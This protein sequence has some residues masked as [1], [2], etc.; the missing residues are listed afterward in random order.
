MAEELKPWEKAAQ[1]EAK[2][3][4]KAAAMQGAP[5]TPLS[6]PAAPPSQPNM[7]PIMQVPTLREAAGGLGAIGLGLAGPGGWAA[8]LATAT[9]GGA[10]GEA[11]G[12]IYDLSNNLKVENDKLAGVSS[13]FKEVPAPSSLK[14]SLYG[15]GKEGLAQGAFEGVAGGVARLAGGAIR[16]APRAVVATAE[17]TSAGKA[18]LARLRSVE[19]A[20]KI[21]AAEAEYASLQQTA[22]KNLE[23]LASLAGKELSAER[24]AQAQFLLRQ[25]Y[26]DNV[27]QHA[28]FAQAAGKGESVDLKDI[29]TRFSKDVEEILPSKGAPVVKANLSE[30]FVGYL[31]EARKAIK[32]TQSV[33]KF[34]DDPLHPIQPGT[35]AQPAE[36]TQAEIKAAAKEWDMHPVAAE[37][38]LKRM[39]DAG[40]PTGLPKVLTPEEAKAAAVE[41][42][43]NRANEE[44]ALRAAD[45][46]MTLEAYNKLRG[47]KEMTAERY[48][49]LFPNM[50]PAKGAAVPVASVPVASSEPTKFGKILKL[51]KEETRAKAEKVPLD[52][53][54]YG[55]SNLKK[56][57]DEGVKGSMQASE[58]GVLRKYLEEWQ[59]AATEAFANLKDPGK[60]KA[61]ELFKKAYGNEAKINEMTMM[62]VAELD[63]GKLA[64]FITDNPKTVRV[65]REMSAK[66]KKIPGEKTT[67]LDDV[68]TS[69]LE[70]LST[71]GGKVKMERFNTELK[72]YGESAT[73]LFDGDR[74]TLDRY[75]EMGKKAEDLVIRRAQ[76]PAL[77]SPSTT[78]QKAWEAF[79]D[80]APAYGGM[81]ATAIGGGTGFVRGGVQGGMTGAAAGAAAGLAAEIASRTIPPA[82]LKRIA[83]NPAA[84]EKWV[85]GFAMAG[86]TTQDTIQLLADAIRLSYPKAAMAIP[87]GLVDAGGQATGLK[88]KPSPLPGPY[89][90]R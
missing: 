24:A 22:E 89:Q 34:V 30:K 14:E 1:A 53:L 10:L 2:P 26:L 25:S 21:K 86:A 63:P 29:A 50:A 75:I 15:I 39:R 70:G 28:I 51:G 23:G 78:M 3:W 6:M 55:I 54:I 12:Q 90:K 60:A 49:E 33:E 84:Y 66:A 40:E 64:G 42:A 4:E 27:E 76:E 8:G 19:H 59:D 37:K 17:A 32:T 57:I 45:E 68:R 71:E 67:L 41:S 87:R 77:P 69:F 65:I 82:V 74:A 18:E 9:F 62:K 35:V 73:A 72:K 38:E 46:G 81:L 58:T 52:S 31:R 85:R 36:I 48:I 47:R 80:K 16:N 79:V 61:W 11:M 43:V 44:A 83:E 56:A 13:D 20:A 7:G 88:P 5:P